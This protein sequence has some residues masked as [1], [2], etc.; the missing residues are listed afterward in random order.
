MFI[1]ASL[2][3]M[4][5]NIPYMWAGHHITLATYAQQRQRASDTLHN[6]SAAGRRARRSMSYSQTRPPVCV[7]GGSIGLPFLYLCPS[8]PVV[9]LVV[10]SEEGEG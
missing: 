5:A 3:L 9:G 10:K 8:L 2:L 6:S 1:Y 4:L 7:C